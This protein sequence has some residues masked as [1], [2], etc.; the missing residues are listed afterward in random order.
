M[1]T[2]LSGCYFSNQ[3]F[4]P[5][6]AFTVSTTPPPTTFKVCAPEYLN[7][8]GS[9]SAIQAV[10]V[11]STNMLVN[12]G[13]TNNIVSYGRLYSPN[14]SYE[15]KSATKT[16]NVRKTK[17][18]FPYMFDGSRTPRASDIH[19]NK[20]CIASQDTKYVTKSAVATSRAIKSRNQHKEI[21]ENSTIIL[22]KVLCQFTS[23]RRQ[24]QIILKLMS[25]FPSG[26]TFDDKILNIDETISVFLELAGKTLDELSL[27]SINKVWHIDSLVTCKKSSGVEK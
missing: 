26:K 19:S 17:D 5:S 8:N 1:E 24:Y 16:A 14:V 27:N 12:G 15:N 11:D 3:C 10:E 21:S 9:A 23:S 2:I 7:S 4:E 18:V 6:Q 13:G 22:C 25:R 20:A